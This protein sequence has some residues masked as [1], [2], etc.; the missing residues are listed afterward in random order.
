[1]EIEINEDDITDLFKKAMT[2]KGKDG[3]EEVDVQLFV[4]T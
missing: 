1:M 2:K 3:K 4:E